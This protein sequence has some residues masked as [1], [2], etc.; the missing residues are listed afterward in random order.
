[1]LTYRFM[2]WFSPVLRERKNDKIFIWYDNTAVIVLIGLCFCLSSLIILCINY[3]IYDYNIYDQ[4][5]PKY[6][7]TRIF[8]AIHLPG[9]LILKI[10]KIILDLWKQ[11]IIPEHILAKC[12]LYKILLTTE[13]TVFPNK[14]I[15]HCMP[16]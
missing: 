4:C 9:K 5:V 16:N 13:V 10:A 6:V 15:K 8:A 12:D 1:M 2:L 7:I 14:I 11:K 3:H